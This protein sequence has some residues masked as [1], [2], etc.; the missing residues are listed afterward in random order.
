LANHKSAKKRARQALKRRARNRHRISGVR[1][2]VR[3]A[4]EAMAGDDPES[5]GTAVRNAES[6]LR[7]AASK[8]VIPKT[9]VSRQVARLH[10]QLHAQSS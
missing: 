6:Q 4:R 2:A 9:R 10:K 1:T 8:G 7:R 5:A 3:R